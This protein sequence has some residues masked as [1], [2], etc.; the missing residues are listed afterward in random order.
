ML[1]S[2]FNEELRRYIAAYIRRQRLKKS[3]P[4]VEIRS[5]TEF[6]FPERIQF[7]KYI[8]IGIDCY[9]HGAGGIE[10]GTGSCIAGKVV[11]LSENHRWDGVE[12]CAI[13]FDNISIQKKVIIGDNVWIGHG[14]MI[15]PGTIIGEGAVIAAGSVVTKDVPTLALVAGS[16][17]KLIKFRDKEKYFELKTQNK[18]WRKIKDN[19]IAEII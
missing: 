16:P 1:K 7:G 5:G 4:T 18:I 13:P 9:F 19:F 11:I 2:L 10:I 8:Y 6:I 3:N 14:A 15:M 17:A 12:L